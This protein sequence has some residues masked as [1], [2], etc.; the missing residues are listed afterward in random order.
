MKISVRTLPDGTKAAFD[1]TGNRV[2]W[3]SAVQIDLDPTGR[4]VLWL[5]VF[6]FS[7]EITLGTDT[8]ATQAAPPAP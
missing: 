3:I 6:A 2:S 8:P 4:P 5:A 7:N 1:E